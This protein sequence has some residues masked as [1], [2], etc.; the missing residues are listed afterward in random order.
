MRT[1]LFAGFLVATL[2]TI[3][4]HAFACTNL[5]QNSVACTI[6][7]S[8][9]GTGT[10]SYVMT[11]SFSTCIDELDKP[12]VDVTI[13]FSSFSYTD[14]SGSTTP[15]AGTLQWGPGPYSGVYQGGS[16]GNGEYVFKSWAIP[17]GTLKFEYNEAP[18]VLSATIS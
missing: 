18:L 7:T 6:N 14:A 16:C 11:L 3:S 17:G 2:L 10:F 1:V 13:L 15:L 5:T 12:G 8:P 9:A 4:D